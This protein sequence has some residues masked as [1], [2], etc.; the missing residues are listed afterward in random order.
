MIFD[1]FIY[2]ILGNRQ[3]KGLIFFYF[4][5]VARLSHQIIQN[6][7]CTCLSFVLKV[8]FS[9]KV[10]WEFENNLP[11]KGQLILGYCCGTDGH[12]ETRIYGMGYDFECWREYLIK[13]QNQTKDDFL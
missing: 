11:I 7:S 5:N 12:W 9:F 2:N 10:L 8:D 1:I 13:K 3:V 4:H 6:E